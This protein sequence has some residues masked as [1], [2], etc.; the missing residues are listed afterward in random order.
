MTE[1]AEKKKREPVFFKD[2]YMAVRNPE[3]GFYICK[4]MQN[5][6]IGARNIKIQ[7]FSNEPH[8][9]PAKDNPKGDI[10][11]PDFYDKT[12]IDGLINLLQAMLC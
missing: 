10:Y 2:E 3:D 8:I 4:A 7:W 6:Y 1:S 5:I 11:A 9:I 12:G